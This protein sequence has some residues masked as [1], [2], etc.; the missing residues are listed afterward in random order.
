MPSVEFTV[1]QIQ[2]RFDA[3]DRIGAQQQAQRRL[4]DRGEIDDGF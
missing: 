1:R 4:V 3:L 2:L